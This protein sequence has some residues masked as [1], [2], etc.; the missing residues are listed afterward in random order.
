MKAPK[1]AAEL[2]ADVPKS[3]P[4]FTPQ[5]GYDS[6]YGEGGP[7]APPGSTPPAINRPVIT[8]KK[9]PVT[10]VKTAAFDFGPQSVVDNGPE[11]S[12]A[13]KATA[14]AASNKSTIGDSRDGFGLSVQEQMDMA[15]KQMDAKQAEEDRKKGIVRPV[16]NATAPA[17]AVAGPTEAQI[18]EE[19]LARQRARID[20][21]NQLY[22]DEYR[23]AKER[24]TAR[25][26]TQRA[27]SAARGTIGSDFG[28]AEQKV[29][30][31]INVGE[32]GAI[33]AKQ[34]AEI[35][36]IMNEADKSIQDRVAKAQA[37]I[38]AQQE[39]ADS[40]KKEQD[41]LAIQ[42]G[43][44]DLQ[45]EKAKQDAIAAGIKPIETEDG[46]I[47]NAF[48][49]AVIYKGK[50]KAQSPMEVS[51]GA[52]IYDPVTGKALY[53]A[54]ERAGST[55][56]KIVKINGE[57]YVQQDDGSF[58]KPVVPSAP[59]AVQQQ[60][61]DEV[62]AL[63]DE[64]KN[65]KNLSSAVGPI[66]SKLPT[67]F[68]GTADFEAKFKN[69]I[70]KITID[71]LPLLKGPMS[72]K[73]IA[74]L[75]EQAS[76][77]TT[78]MSEPGFRAELDRLKEKFIAA[79]NNIGPQSSQG[80]QPAADLAEKINTAITSG[81]SAQEVVNHLKDNPL[82]QK[83]L[84]EGYTP[85]EIVDHLKKSNALSTAQNGSTGKIVATMIGSRS[86]KVDSS[87]ADK[88][89]QA[90]SDYFA[91]TGK[92]IQVNQDL[93]TSAQQQELYNKFKSGKGGRA[94]PP[95]HSFHEKGLAVDV[96]N[97]QEAMPYLQKYGFKNPLADDK[98]H[99]SIGEFA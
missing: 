76:A 22:V 35:Q 46:S 67:L 28:T 72:D 68:G 30:E 98:G 62:I 26:G 10:P 16:I 60:K 4:G 5:A 59:S 9:E 25:T 58:V 1:T 81:Y 24:A 50:P 49:G 61:A 84:N 77:L 94:A 8:P 19:E 44:L 13:A 2:L 18:R 79:K 11:G 52:T 47:I 42:T 33:R 17:P 57:D 92:H 36:A 71:A 86:V 74:F 63:I 96:T 87:I 45:K 40:L 53:T 93:R 29:V 66:S 27:Q 75:K 41:Q 20:S 95:G 65:D 56:Q 31:D 80:V 89:A 69:L 32:E 64:L 90:D 43:Q 23:K 39:R 12:A 83:A 21:I 55:N 85:Q 51:P 6:E 88:L 70:G 7:G 3:Y 99:F 14:D 97:W 37:L 78:N 91:A 54:P 73:D 38:L 15:Q 34:A 82:V 48:T